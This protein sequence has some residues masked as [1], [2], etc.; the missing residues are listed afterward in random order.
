MDE[1][2][3][4][5]W[6]FFVI[7]YLHDIVIHSDTWEEHRKPNKCMLAAA[8]CTHLHK[9]GQGVKPEESTIEAVMAK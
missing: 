7:V 5:I 4:G 6:Q 2:P 8:N 3:R 9:I 1:V